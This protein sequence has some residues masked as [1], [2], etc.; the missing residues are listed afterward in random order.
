[1][2]MH[3]SSALIRHELRILR[4][5]P[6]PF[7]L[8]FVLPLV[9]MWL[10]RPAFSAIFATIGGSGNGAAQA[11]PGMAVL[12]AMFLVANVA[13]GFQRERDWHTWARLRAGGASPIE[14]AAGKLVP[15]F[16]VVTGLMLVLFAVGTFVFDLRIRGPA[17][18]IV[19]LI[20]IFGAW[21]TTCGAIVAAVCKTTAQA[22]AV[23]NLL[24][25]GVGGLGGVLIP[26]ET[27]PHWVQVAA[28]GTPTWWV[29]QGLRSTINGTGFAAGPILVLT[30]W[31]LFTA[32]VA[33]AAVEHAYVGDNL[34]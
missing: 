18:Q 13:F 30:F 14:L 27:L 24:S 10:L 12:Y 23:A 29:M 32:A 33:V 15:G 3:R 8:S 28:H 4:R 11:V 2:S 16:V 17:M 19:A 25:L 20:L 31:L 7:I 22:T 21:L 9:M 5:D 1:M 6:L 34:R 26:A